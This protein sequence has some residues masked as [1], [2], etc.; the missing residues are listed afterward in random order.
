MVEDT[1]VTPMVTPSVPTA[2]DI[3]DT[4][5]DFNTAPSAFANDDTAYIGAITK[6]ATDQNQIILDAQNP[7]L[8][9]YEGLTWMES[10]KAIGYEFSLAAA[11]A[12]AIQNT[13]T[14]AGIDDTLDVNHDPIGYLQESHPMLYKELTETAYQHATSDIADIFANGSEELLKSFALAKNQK[15]TDWLVAHSWDILRKRK[16]LSEAGVTNWLVGGFS[17]L[18]LDG[19]L[20][21]G[22]GA[23]LGAVRAP[24]IAGRVARLIKLE[25]LSNVGQAAAAN[26]AY[27]MAKSAAIVGAY[28]GVD[29]AV[30]DITDP[31][32]GMADYVIGI[33]AGALLGTAAAPLIRKFDSIKNAP[34]RKELHA[35]AE[36][37]IQRRL[38]K[39]DDMGTVGSQAT[40]RSEGLDRLEQID[41]G[42]WA[43]SVLAGGIEHLS[44]YVGA[45]GLVQGFRSTRRRILDLT[46]RAGKEKNTNLKTATSMMNRVVRQSAGADTD[47]ARTVTVE[48]HIMAAQEYAITVEEMGRRAAIKVQEEHFQVSP[49]IGG[50]ARRTLGNT[51]LLELAPE[52]F[53]KKA[54]RRILNNNAPHEIEL[55]TWASDLARAK[56][57]DVMAEVNPKNLDSTAWGY[58]NRLKKEWEELGWTP[59]QIDATAKAVD[60]ISK[61]QDTFYEAN[62]QR[63]RKL[64]LVR[65][66]QYIPHYRS[67]VWNTEAIEKDEIGF[68][69]F[70]YKVYAGHTPDEEWVNELGLGRYENDAK[71]EA[72]ADA[73]G[74]V[75][76]ADE[77]NRPTID[78]EAGERFDTWA[79]QNPV[80]AHQAAREW[81]RIHLDR[82]T[83]NITDKMDAI[84]KNVA[85]LQSRR[86]RAAMQKK[87]VKDIDAKIAQMEKQFAKLTK[88]LEDKHKNYI[89]N[90]VDETYKA[91]K[92]YRTAYGFVPEKLVRDSRFFKN[93]QI[94]L[95][96]AELLPEGQK[97]LVRNEDWNMRSYVNTA[98][99]QAA[100]KENFAPLIGIKAGESFG[101]FV[102]RVKERA[103]SDYNESITSISQA[104]S[105]GARKGEYKKLVDERKEVEK[106]WDDLIDEVLRRK[107]MENGLGMN[108]FI[109]GLQA[110]ASATTLGFVLASMLQD[111]AVLAVAGGRMITGFKSVFRSQKKVWEEMIENGDIELAM[112]L[113]G[114]E[115]Y[116]HRIIAQR[117][118][119]DAWTHNL[120]GG[121]LLGKFERTAQTLAQ[122]NGYASFMHQWNRK[123]KEMFGYD[124]AVQLH[125]DI[126]EIG[127]DKLPTG[128]R[129]LYARNGIGKADFDWLKGAKWKPY[130]NGRLLIPDIEDW[131]K[132]RKGQE[133]LIKYKDSIRSMSDEGMIAPGIGDRPTFAHHPLGRVMFTF[134]SF[135]YTVGN[136][137]WVP[138]VQKGLVHGEKGQM[139]AAMLT[140]LLLGM[141]AEGWR[142]GARNGK[143]GLNEWYHESFETKQGFY[144]LMKR[145]YLRSNFSFGMTSSASD[146]LGHLLGD[147]IN[148]MAHLAVGPDFNLIDQEF[149]RLKVGQGV[150][151]AIGGPILGMVG[152]AETGVSAAMAGDWDKAQK[153]AALRTPLINTIVFQSLMEALNAVME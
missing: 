64:D 59:A 27:D 50:K 62:W 102:E 11:G 100:F 14:Q 1:L 53:S 142:E 21:A 114:A 9:T 17:G 105:R 152:T 42:D 124:L 22:G 35:A 47:V 13:W 29:V 150:I 63:L 134:T 36:A 6:M 19:A 88:K 45:K 69:N 116:D 56:G 146:L 141:A 133:M 148:S 18:L 115:A 110:S 121:G 101:D 83:D 131:Q 82:V 40:L 143:E 10:T 73:D 99:R 120:P 46:V 44:G 95:N 81:E 30:H 84:E 92:D 48:Q 75:T 32:I 16:A 66:D 130:D 7:F 117:M 2:P 91:L 119:Y 76:N 65:E 122:L 136:R 145:T 126:T 43:G 111:V 78:I 54:Q 129:A 77:V 97:F 24:F 28:G 3:Q 137:M 98:G 31:D 12:K 26:K 37:D 153:L 58:I 52:E 123:F 23:I 112:N 106:L 85:T 103:L 67:Q 15:Q 132:T 144:N 93:R 55:K 57:N 140:S 89:W 107:V 41:Y 72:K 49:K 39:Y 70:I 33:G 51:Q 20:T 74:K 5:G 25:E 96:G 60:E 86:L 38:N 109:S 151:G 138:M 113:R 71:L 8:Q 80:A 104:Q 94:F 139:M 87:K 34:L 147:P 149:A 125:K 127:W 108:R 135:A 118:D 68:K 128:M 61:I 90:R 79:E 4:L